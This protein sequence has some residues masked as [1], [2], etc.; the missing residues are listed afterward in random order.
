SEQL[1]GCIEVVFDG[2]YMDSTIYINDTE[3][4]CWKYGYTTFGFDITKYLVA[5]R[6]TITVKINHVS[7][8]TRWY[9][10][11]G[12]FRNVW[13]EYKNL[14]NIVR[15]G[16]Y[17]H[18]EKRDC[19]WNIA[20]ET[21]VSGKY[22]SIRHTLLDSNGL[23]IASCESENS[24]QNIK[25]TDPQ[26]WDTKSPYVYKLKTELIYNQSVVDTQMNCMGF[27]TIEFST[28]DGFILNGETLKLHGVCMHHDL[29]ALGS[30]FNPVA[31]WRQINILKS[32]GV[33]SIRT[34]HNP[35]AREVMDICDEAGIIVISEC[36]DM[37]ELPKTKYD[38]GNYFPEWYKKDVA[39]WIRRDRNH[40]SVI[41]WSIGNEIYD[42]HK[43]ERGLEVA[44]LLDE[45]VKK[46]DPLF[47]ARSTIGSNFMSGE[48]AQKVSD[49][50]KLAGYN[51]AEYL[52]DEHHEKYPDWFIYGSETA[53]TVR[54]RGVYHFPIDSPLLVD[55]DTQCSDLGNSVVGWGGASEKTWVDDRDRKFCGGQYIWTGFDYIGEPTPYST[56]NSYFGIVDTAGFPKSSYYFY[57]AVWADNSS[58][59]FIKII[60]HWDWNIGQIIDVITYSSE[61][62][63]ELFLNGKSL[64]R[65]SVDLL[66]DDVLHGHWRVKYE[67]GELT[68]KAYDE[69]W[70]VVATDSAKSF[71]EP[72]RVVAVAERN[73]IKSD[74][75]DLQ[76]IQISVEDNDNVI[77]ENARNRITVEVDGPARLVG[78][79][80]GD[81]TDYDS[82]KGNNKRL[83][84]G[85]LLAIIQAGFE[86][87]DVKVRL[88]S[89]GLIGT[90]V[91]FKV[92]HCDKP[93]GVSIENN[94]PAYVQEL[95]DRI[96]VRKIELSCDS[97]ILNENKK[98]ANITAKLLPENTDFPDLIW[99]CMTKTGVETNI[100]EVVSIDS[101]VTVTAKGDGDFRLRAMS[102][103]SGD[104][105]Q[106]IS[107]LEMS[108]SGLGD[109]VRS[110]YKYTSA[111]LYDISN[112]PLNVVERGAIDKTT[113]R[114]IIGFSNVDFGNDGSDILLLSIGNQFENKTIP[115]EIWIGNP[116]EVGAEKVC[117]VD[118][119]YNGLWDRFAPFEFILPKRIKGTHTI[120]FVVSTHCIFGGFEFAKHNKAF[121]KNS[122]INND[123]VYG[124]EFTKDSGNDM[125][126]HIGNNVLINFNGFD[127]GESGAS[128]ITICGSTP[129]DTNTI[130]LRFT[131]ENGIRKTSLL[132]FKG[133]SEVQSF[134]INTIYKK[135]DISF[136]FL[137]GSNFN[138]SWFMF[139]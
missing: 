18:T 89:N 136:V 106:V 5:G 13:I 36:F 130:S 40:P 125:I 16:V 85:K 3:A 14:S 80:N 135:Q 23:E 22:D 64:G 90:E 126:S 19:C 134:D 37:W 123:S 92:I 45:E 112:Y 114:T 61:K 52:Y 54:S 84:S 38:Y 100:A 4:F 11:A 124:D 21:E 56:K 139:G 109:A 2:V 26:L 67:K 51:Y 74:G 29:G 1:L 24:S 68:A 104:I 120:S 91:N 113:S 137:P 7:P 108:V 78:L 87:G 103:N 73:D 96:N 138:F 133:N 75:R 27:R 77:V 8:N 79:D 83:F 102:K 98:V 121:D 15:D 35:P 30:A 57:K 116:D 82:Y 39:S 33:N 59:P 58:N 46:H 28:D 99:K 132:E 93:K 31:F 25:A 63:I 111:S 65:Q 69:N 48:N 20:I 115:I 12:I 55:E 6:N 110:A 105:P 9:S 122:A 81:S 44:K 41:M 129:N 86:T 127:F 53:S 101:G 70:N 71:S 117:N 107:E 94:Y 62:N 60:P 49:Y 42:T 47:N 119:P 66:N 43:D 76:F 97:Q 50:L 131:D 95:D 17:I 10:G 88:S 72:T 32:F 118:F 128:K 34:S